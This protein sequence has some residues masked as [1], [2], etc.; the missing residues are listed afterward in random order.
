V[1]LDLIAV[2]AEAKRG[3]LPRTGAVERL[4]VKVDDFATAYTHE[5][6]VPVEVRVEA[7]GLVQRIDFAQQTDL[8]ES[9]D[10]LVDRGM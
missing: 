3:Y 7:A 6:M 9:M 10:V 8:D 4:V 2:D 1:G 5:V